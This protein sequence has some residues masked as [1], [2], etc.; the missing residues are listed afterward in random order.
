MNGLPS[1]SGRE[2]QIF[3]KTLDDDTV[4]KF[5]LDVNQSSPRFRKAPDLEALGLTPSCFQ[6]WSFSKTWATLIEISVEF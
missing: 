3:P 5:N 4:L 6:V 1:F 2:V